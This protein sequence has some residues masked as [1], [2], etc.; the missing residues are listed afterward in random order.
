MLA[1]LETVETKK[2]GIFVMPKDRIE[3]KS[4]AVVSHRTEL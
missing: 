3:I 2:E 1:K 4:G